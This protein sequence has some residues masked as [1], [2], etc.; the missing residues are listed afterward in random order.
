[1]VSSLLIVKIS[2]LLHDPEIMWSA[3]VKIK[4]IDQIGKHEVL[5]FVYHTNYFIYIFKVKHKHIQINL[6]Y[7]ARTIHRKST[8]LK[9]QEIN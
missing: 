3:S 1:M 5:G 9:G 7:K 2:L 6:L 4:S 8:S